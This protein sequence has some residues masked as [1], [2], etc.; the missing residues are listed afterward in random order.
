MKIYINESF[1]IKAIGFSDDDSLTEIVIDEG[2]LLSD[3]SDFMIFNYCC[4]PLENG[5]EIYPSMDYNTLK[6]LDNQENKI[7]ILQ[8]ENYK[9]NEIAKEQ[10]RLLVDNTYKIVMLE[11][12]LGG[13]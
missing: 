8:E 4:R 1:E 3:L 10:D 9:L 2:S 11:M 5:Y 7:S 6:L 13:M 12:S